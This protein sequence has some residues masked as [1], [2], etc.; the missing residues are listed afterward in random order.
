MK[1]EENVPELSSA[2]RTSRRRFLVASAGVAAAAVVPHIWVP[3]PAIAQSIGRGSIKHLL[4][5]RLSGGF[6]FPTAFNANVAGEF[7]PFGAAGSVAEGTEWGVGSLLA[8]APF[9]EGAGG[10]GA[11]AIGMRSVPEIA[12]QITVIPCVDHEPISGS[13]DGNHGTGL[14]RY[15]TGYADGT[16]GLFTMINYGLRERFAAANAEG[17]LILPPFVLGGAGMGRGLGK[18]AA[19]R[20]P[21]LSGANLDQFGFRAAELPGWASRLVDNYDTRM[22]DRQHPELRDS[23]DAYLETRKATRAYSEL[24]A[25]DVLKINNKSTELVDGISN[26]ELE[27][28]FGNDGAAQRIRLAL[29]LFH[30]GSAAAYLDQGGYDMHSGEEN[31]LPGRLTELSR[32]ISALEAV[33]KRMDHPEGGKY[34]DHTVVVFGSEFSRTARA[35]RFNSARGSDHGGDLETRW[36][37]MPFMGGPIARPGRV[38]GAT[39]ASDLAAEGKVYSYR[40]VAKTLMDGLG[41]DHQEFFPEAADAP[42]D[43]LFA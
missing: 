12:N 30:F 35:S 42:F 41:C 4:Y 11:R 10:E 32:L 17:R 39:R 22:R 31:Q 25:S 26:A 28:A 27:S 21:L 38:L 18:Y 1:R 40:S 15:Y 37:S 43:D 3:K 9:L 33:L 8:P 29:R 14:E 20:P 5:I 23:V 36:M 16:V 7:N 6:R 19:H 34:W 13:A 24:F 2:R